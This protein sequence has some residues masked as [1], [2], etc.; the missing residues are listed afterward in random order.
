MPEARGEGEYSWYSGLAAA[1]DLLL[2]GIEFN[3]HHFHSW[4]DMVLVN[5]IM[6]AN[7]RPFTYD[8][9]IALAYA[10]FT[11]L[12]P[13][14]LRQPISTGAVAR[15]L[16]IPASTAHRRVAVMV[17][18]GILARKSRGVMVAD[19][20]LQNPARVEDSRTTILHARQILLRLA[21]GDFR[22]HA[23]ERCYRGE[24]PALLP[25]R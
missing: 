20:T 11:H 3:A 24:R 18:E 14:T 22:F 1:H 7:A 16:G 19:T 10:D 23:P 4:T 8:R 6:C 17:E 5:A 2:T 25:F 21:N 12:P 13:D 9:D 15:A